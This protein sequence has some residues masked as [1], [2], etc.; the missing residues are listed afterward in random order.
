MLAI[1]RGIGVNG[2]IGSGL[3]GSGAIG[4]G[5]TGSGLIV[6]PDVPEPAE[7]AAEPIEPVADIGRPIVE[8]IPVVVDAEPMVAGIDVEAMPPDPDTII[9]ADVDDGENVREICVPAGICETRIGEV[10]AAAAPERPGMI[11]AGLTVPAGAEPIAGM[12]A[13]PLM[14]TTI[15]EPGAGAVLCALASAVRSLRRAR[16]L[17]PPRSSCTNRVNWAPVGFV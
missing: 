15:G 12:D 11:E 6:P 10:F 9:G 8:A 5:L 4:S 13:W 2:A 14:T 7:A 1:G 16:T 17:I 3:T